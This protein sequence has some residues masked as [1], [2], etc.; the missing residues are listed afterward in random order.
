MTSIYQSGQTVTI[1]G[2]YEVVGV[3]PIADKSLT[4][5]REKPVRELRVGD[6][7]PSF[8]GR[9]VSWH[10]MQVQAVTNVKQ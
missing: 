3:K 10:L 9:E 6:Q 8:E 4:E 5:R 2:I 7:F 1:A